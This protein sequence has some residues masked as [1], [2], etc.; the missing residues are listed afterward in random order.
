MGLSSSY[1]PDL[2]VEDPDGRFVAT[3]EIKN[4]LNLTSDTAT[5]LRHNMA[6]RGSLLQTPY[7]LILS[8]DTGFL[9]KEAWKQ[10]PDAPPTYEFPMSSVWGRY[11]TR[12]PGE[13]LYKIELEFLVLQWLT[14]L[15]AGT[16]QTSEEPEKTL[17]L[18]NFN[19]TIKDATVSIEDIE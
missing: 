10:E 11:V 7:F 3:I 5:Q 2:I 9:W 8:Q 4:L 15:A 6:I 18:A 14:D 13:R 1:R 12:K 17:A 19:K 16:P